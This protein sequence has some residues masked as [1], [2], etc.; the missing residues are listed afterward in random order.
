[1]TPQ[2]Q[3][4]RIAELLELA[5]AEGLPLAVRPETVCA[6]EDAGWLIDPFTG[7]LW[8]DPNAGAYCLADRCAR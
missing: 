6:L 5:A 7:Q 4:P 2:T 1:M 3:D 8:R